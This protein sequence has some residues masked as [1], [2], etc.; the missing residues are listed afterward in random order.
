MN[1]ITQSIQNSRREIDLV[2]S[3][4][5]SAYLHTDES[6][7]EEKKGEI[8]K[9]EMN[10]YYVKERCDKNRKDILHKQ[11][12]SRDTSTRVISSKSLVKK[13]SEIF[14]CAKI[15]TELSSNHSI[16]N[17]ISNCNYSNNKNKS[18]STS[19]STNSDLFEY[20]NEKEIELSISDKEI[21]GDRQLFNYRKQK[22]L[23]K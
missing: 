22:L 6:G 7:I 19:T 9:K 13:K 16:V 11:I 20:E 17:D 23:G 21:Y 12:Q 1:K 2:D 18:T 5:I 14:P 3:L 10:E 8:K 15:K 4:N